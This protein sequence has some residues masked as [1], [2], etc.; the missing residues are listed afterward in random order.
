[1]TQLD[2]TTEFQFSLTNEFFQHQTSLNGLTHTHCIGNQETQEPTRHHF[3][4]CQYLVRSGTI[5]LSMG[6]SMAC[7]KTSL[8]ILA[9]MA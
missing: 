9:A 8:L 3:L 6:A 1:M 5:L 7:L 2:L 4:Q